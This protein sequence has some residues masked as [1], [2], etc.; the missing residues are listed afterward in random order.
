MH[1]AHYAGLQFVIQN[2]TG[3]K[4][5]K[6]KLSFVRKLAVGYVKSAFPILRHSFIGN[7][8]EY[9]QKSDS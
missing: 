3:R 5:Q 6:Q 7:S 8:L 2:M 4:N 9:S 1:I